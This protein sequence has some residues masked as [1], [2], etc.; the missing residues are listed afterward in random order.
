MFHDMVPALVLSLALGADLSEEMS[1]V[2]GCSEERPCSVSQEFK[3][4]ADGAP[5]RVCELSQGGK[6]LPTGVTCEVREFWLTVGKKGKPRLLLSLCNDGYGSA[7][8]GE[9]D[10]QV[11]P[12]RLFH[13]QVG[14]A[15][16]RWAVMREIQLNPLVLLKTSITWF[17]TEAPKFTD[18][19]KWSWDQFTGERVRMFSLCTED[20]HPDLRDDVKPRALRS[21]LVPKVAVTKAWAEGGWKQASLGGC[22]ARASYP[23]QG[24]AGTDA[25]SLLKVLALND[26]EFI[27]EITDDV[28]AKGDALHFWLFEKTVSPLDGCLGKEGLQAAQWVMDIPSGQARPGHNAR[29]GV[30]VAEV[31]QVGQQVRL[32]V[33]L[34][35]GAWPSVTFAYADSDDGKFVERTM[36]TSQFVFAQ[37]AT[38]GSVHALERKVAMCDVVNGEL[39]PKT[40]LTVPSKGPAFPGTTK[41]K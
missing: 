17:P 16:R 7:G 34:P 32:R 30:P 1:A 2:I 25:D 4:D 8:V 39:A 5:R 31:A 15:E 22:S 37:A 6:G 12:N 11:K 29:F 38:L 23:L 20:G 35:E 26:T 27:I 21:A 33:R 9:D 13:E 14:G 10:V 36:A 3:A 28:F 19:F 41:V 40:L 24:A 18:E